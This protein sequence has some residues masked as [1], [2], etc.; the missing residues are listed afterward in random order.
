[1]S[2]L[3]QC[4]GCSK[5][6]RIAD[7]LAGRKGKCPA[8]GSIF[9]IPVGSS[10]EN[11][12]AGLT[13]QAEQPAV[14]GG[15]ASSEEPDRRRCRSAV[16]SMVLGILGFVSGFFVGGFLALLMGLAAVPLG[17]VALVKIRRSRGVLAG[18]AL[19]IAGLCIGLVTMV[20]GAGALVSLSAAGPGGSGLPPPK[21]PGARA[22]ARQLHCRANLHRIGVAIFS[23][24]QDHDDRFPQSLEVLVEKGYLENAEFLQCPGRKEHLKCDFLLVP[25]ETL[26]Q[27]GLWTTAFDRKENHGGFG[28]NVLFADGST[29]W[30]AEED[31]RTTLIWGDNPVLKKFLEEHGSD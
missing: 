31:L 16:A 19:A 25:Y 22:Q 28:R 11:S 30:V 24:A 7:G 12:P 20:L 10:T 6:L 4:P 29:K 13:P 1:M 23:Y 21:Q 17:V 5:S 27:A 26:K 18:K 2:I 3:L 9:E 15:G 14:P 8:C